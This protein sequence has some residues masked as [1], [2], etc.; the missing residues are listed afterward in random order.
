MAIITAHAGLAFSQFRIGPRRFDYDEVSDST[1]SIASRGIGQPRWTLGVSS[2]D[3]M[4]DAQAALWLQ[5]IMKLRGRVNHLAIYDYVRTAPRGT[6]RGTLTLN[7]AI[8][9]GATSAIITGGVG[10]AGTTLKVGDWLQFGTGLGSQFVFVTDDATANGSGVITVNFEHPA[11][12]A[13]SG[14]AAVTWDKPLCY[15]K[16]ESTL[17]SWAYDAGYLTTSGIDLDLLEQWQ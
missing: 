9:I 12:V 7:S 16:M 17:P 11:R 15:F 2:P 3:K 6:M 4:G 1:G 8:S 14:G 5:M 13:F 10:Q